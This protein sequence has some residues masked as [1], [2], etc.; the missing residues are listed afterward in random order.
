MELYDT[1]HIRLL[2][3]LD[4]SVAKEEG[5]FPSPVRAEILS[6]N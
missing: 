6:G 1:V 5:Y 3:V 2:D 4:H